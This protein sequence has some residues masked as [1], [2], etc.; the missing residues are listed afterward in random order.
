MVAELV[1][2]GWTLGNAMEM[3]YLPLFEGTKIDGERSTIYKT[4]S[5]Y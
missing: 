3:I 2:D 4:I 5:S 1:S